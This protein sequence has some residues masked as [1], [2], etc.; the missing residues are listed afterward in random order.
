[1]NNKKIAKTVAE[2]L[3]ILWEEKLFKSWCQQAK[4]IEVLSRRG[5]HFTSAELSMALKR[6]K[7]LTRSGKKGSYKYIQK[8]PYIKE[9]LKIKK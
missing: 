5:N 4:I 9:E 8:H 3:E 2:A 1:M 7:Y 6:A